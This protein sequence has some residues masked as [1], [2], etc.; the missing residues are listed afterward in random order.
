MKVKPS[1]K[2]GRWS[3]GL[4]SFFL[5]AVIVSLVLVNFLGVLDFGDTWWDVT[6]PVIFSAS[7]AGFVCGLIALKKKD[8]SILVYASVVVGI[9]TILFIFLHSLFIND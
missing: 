8:K 9:L 5:V 1:S 3:V 7:L 6:V 2:L 4:N